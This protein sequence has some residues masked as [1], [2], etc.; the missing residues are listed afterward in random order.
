MARTVGSGC[1]RLFE[2]PVRLPFPCVADVPADDKRQVRGLHAVLQCVR[3]GNPAA[4]SVGHLC[5]ASGEPDGDSAGGY[6]GNAH[7][8]LL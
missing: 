4:I 5:G 8:G 2:C 1:S 3:L 7:Q 6:G